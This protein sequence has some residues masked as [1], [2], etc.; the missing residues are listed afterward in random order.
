MHMARYHIAPRL[1]VTA[2]FLRPV[3]RKPRAMRTEAV[4]SMGA[5]GA[6]HG[7]QGFCSETHGMGVPALL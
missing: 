4:S 1:L 6:G 5:L 2:S 7:T 3:E